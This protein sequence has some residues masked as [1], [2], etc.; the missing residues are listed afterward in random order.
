MADIQPGGVRPATNHEE[1]L[2]R[3]DVQKAVGA[4]VNYTDSGGAVAIRGSGDDAKSFLG[5][6]SH[7]VRDGVQVLIWAGDSDYVCNWLGTKRVA[8]AVDWPKKEIFSQTDLQPY[9]VNGVQKATF[10]SVK[11]LHYVRVFNAGHNVGSYQPETS[12]QLIAQ[13]LSGKG[14]SST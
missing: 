13:S 1:Y 12:L 6:I 11:N 3:A 2:Q 7:I 5:E 10:K 4:R 14:L 8:D 9:T